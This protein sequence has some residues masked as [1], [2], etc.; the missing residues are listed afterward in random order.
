MAI[1]IKWSEVQKDKPIEII[2]ES[3]DHA[4]LYIYNYYILFQAYI[5]FKKYKR[6]FELS[7]PFDV[8]RKGIQHLPLKTQKLFL[9][10][11]TKFKLT[12]LDKGKAKIEKV[13]KYG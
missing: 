8:F 10:G 2:T 7:M 6:V 4:R 1:R 11:K 3:I 12:K 5:D 9:E 13:K